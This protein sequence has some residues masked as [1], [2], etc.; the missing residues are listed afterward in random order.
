[1]DQVL[2]L[3][4]T[5]HLKNTGKVREFCQCGKMGTISFQDLQVLCR[6]QQGYNG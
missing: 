6:K 5:K 4:K 3:K 2:V 1:M